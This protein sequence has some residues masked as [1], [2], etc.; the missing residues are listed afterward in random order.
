MALILSVFHADASK[1][2]RLCVHCFQSQASGDGEWLHVKVPLRVVPAAVHPQPLPFDPFTPTASIVALVA[3]ESASRAQRA[4]AELLPDSSASLVASLMEAL[5]TKDVYRATQL[6]GESSIECINDAFL[7]FL[8][9][10]CDKDNKTM[11]LLKERRD[12]LAAE[13][14]SLRKADEAAEVEKLFSR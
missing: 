1:N 13:V 9:A 5:H 6:I 10:E 7:D 2:D 11:L 4:Q 8:Q 14:A 12:S 3:R